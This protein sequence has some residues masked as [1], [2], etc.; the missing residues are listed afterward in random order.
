[1]EQNRQEGEKEK[2]KEKRLGVSLSGTLVRGISGR[3]NRNGAHQKNNKEIKR[4]T[5]N[6]KETANADG[7][8]VGKFKNGWWNM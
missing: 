3:G 5:Q 8:Q 6:D 4:T 1:V 2:D 7:L